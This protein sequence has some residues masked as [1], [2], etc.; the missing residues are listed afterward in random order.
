M[1]LAQLVFMPRSETQRAS[2]A[3]PS[4]GRPTPFGSAARVEALIRSL[5]ARDPANP[6]AQA[7]LHAGAA[8]RKQAELS[9][10]APAA[11]RP[12][13]DAERSARKRSRS[14]RASDAEA[15]PPAKAHSVA[16]RMELS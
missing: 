2:I 12:R 10:D 16:E 8:V 5:P 3:R 1:S 13:G 14:P 4:W 15:S 9:A 6:P 11:K 7:E